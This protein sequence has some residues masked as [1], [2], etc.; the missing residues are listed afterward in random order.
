MV[1]YERW[2]VVTI[3]VVLIVSYHHQDHGSDEDVVGFNKK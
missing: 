1:Q 3:V 2:Y